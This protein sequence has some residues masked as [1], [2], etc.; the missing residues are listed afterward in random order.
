MSNGFC[1]QSCGLGSSIPNL[2]RV[3]VPIDE[4]YFL[5][6]QQGVD[7]QLF[8]VEPTRCVY[9][10]VVLGAYPWDVEQ[11]SRYPDGWSFPDTEPLPGLWTWRLSI[12]DLLPIP[13]LHGWSANFRQVDAANVDPAHNC[14]RQQ[15]LVNYVPFVFRPDVT[16]VPLSLTDFTPA[17]RQR[18][19]PCFCSRGCPGRSKPHRKYL[20][21]ESNP[22]DLPG[23]DL[24][25]LFEISQQTIDFCQ[26]GVVEPFFG[27]GD[28]FLSLNVINLTDDVNTLN[29]SLGLFF[30]VLG[31]KDYRK[32][33]QW[34]ADGDRHPPLL[35]LCST[36]WTLVSDDHSSAEL[37]PVP[38]WCCTDNQ[39]REWL[40][41]V[42]G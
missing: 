12:D 37:I 33:V 2:I 14:E 7:Y 25:K 20:V 18:T 1:S 13:L 21:R 23:F 30:P 29:W 22:G 28:A 34:S 11:L 24:G 5:D 36:P 17:I 38:E 10:R 27:G 42:F 4:S 40:V 19:S 3:F 31:G 32:L 26:W 16:I 35:S 8:A 39:A 41:R 15:D 9:R 6:Y